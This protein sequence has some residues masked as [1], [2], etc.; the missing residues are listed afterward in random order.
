MPV[1]KGTGGRIKEHDG[2]YH[3]EIPTEDE[4]R[5]SRARPSYDY[6]PSERAESIERTATTQRAGTKLRP[7]VT[8]KRES[9]FGM[10]LGAAGVAILLIM[11]LL[12]LFTPLG[13]Y[14]KSLLHLP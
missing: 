5:M 7:K 6:T 3:D 14:V 13:E 2:G 10:K 4:M 1:K 9:N 8:E 11:L 12:F